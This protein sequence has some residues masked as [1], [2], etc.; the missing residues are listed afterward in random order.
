MTDQ[1]KIQSLSY[2][3]G[4]LRGAISIVYSQMTED[5]KKYVDEIDT[6]IEKTIY[7]RPLPKDQHGTR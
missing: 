1:E 6:V 2:I 7:A 4:V 5:L 3:C